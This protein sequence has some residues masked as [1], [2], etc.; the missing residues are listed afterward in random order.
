MRMRRSG[1]RWMV[2]AMAPWSLATGLVMSFSADA[3]QE[4]S[5]GASL[6]PLSSHAPAQPADLVQA[7]SAG[8]RGRFGLARLPMS[9]AV[10][11]ARL[12]DTP[13][14]SVQP[15]H[16]PGEYQPRRDVK[17][18]VG[19]SALQTPYPVAERLHRSDP[20]VALRPAFDAKW[21]EK[22]AIEATR[23]SALL[24]A[25]DDAEPSSAF[26][27][28]EGEA[29]GPDSVA[30]FQ[31]WPG[32]ESPATQTSRAPASP[33]AGG[34]APTAHAVRDGA[35]PAVARSIA[36]G[37]STPVARDSTP[38]EIAA[39]PRE[40]RRTANAN[41]TIVPRDARPDYAALLDPGHVAREKRCLAE[42]VYFEARSENED[43]Q[44]AVAQVVLNRVNSGLYPESVCG[45]V[46]QNRQ[47][48]NACQFSFACEGKSLKIT[49]PEPWKTA[50][51][52]ADEVA[53]G[54]TYLAD[55]G[56]ATHY[57]ANYVRPRWARRLQKMDVIGNHIFYKLKPGQT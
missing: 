34:S 37:S 4:A 5:F 16:D 28:E 2:A 11:E 1:V 29:P 24:F 41:A 53:A 17:R 46:Y 44:A 38:V 13:V 15:A 21:R 39:L 6:S 23:T 50:V 51:R 10:R 48:R 55:V 25:H 27:Q 54:S 57:H 18:H 14:E 9:G 35:T 36:L 32:D 49:E 52:I 8:D 31:P 26:A 12:I 20:F 19:Q 56:A 40:A 7:A 45:V 42:A 3:G 43:G 33:A 30:S 22:G 47:R